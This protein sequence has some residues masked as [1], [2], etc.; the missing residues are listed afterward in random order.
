M[1]VEG[2]DRRKRT[3]PNE[4]QRPLVLLHGIHQRGHLLAHR[5]VVS[6]LSVESRPIFNPAMTRKGSLEHG[7]QLR[8]L[9]PLLRD[10][11]RSDA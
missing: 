11:P 9:L 6:S 8:P 3:A 7:E 1:L 4:L 2:V 5:D 10:R